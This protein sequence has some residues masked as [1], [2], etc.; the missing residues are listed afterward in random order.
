MSHS[1]ASLALLIA[2]M[3]PVQGAAPVALESNVLQV[4]GQSVR[5]ETFEIPSPVPGPDGE[6]AVIALTSFRLEGQD[7]RPAP[8]V[9]HANGFGLPRLQELGPP[10]ASKG[11]SFWG[12]L[13]ALASAVVLD[14]YHLVS[15]DHRGHGGSGGVSRSMDPFYEIV[16]VRTV[17]DWAEEN[18]SV[19]RDDAGDPLIGTIG[20]SFG[21]GYQLL[22]A[23]FD[24][25]VDAIVPT[26]TWNDLPRS[27]FGFGVLKQG[28]LEFECQ[29]AVR[30]GTRTDRFFEQACGG[31]EQPGAALVEQLGSPEDVRS[32]LETWG[33]SGLGHLE[34]V[35]DQEATGRVLDPRLANVEPRPIDA[36]LMQAS[37]DVL[38][39]LNEALANQRVLER[40]GGDVRLVVLRSGHANPAAG[41]GNGPAT[42]GDLGANEMTLAF[43]ARTLRGEAD[44]TDLPEV[45][46][47]VS[48][49]AS[50]KLVRLP[51]LVAGRKVAV[52]ESDWSEGAWVFHPIE[53]LAEARDLIG[54]PRFT[55]TVAAVE[56]ADQSIG[57]VGLAVRTDGGDPALLSGQLVAL[58][59]GRYVEVELAGVA[60]R[61]DAGTTLGL[62][63]FETHPQ[64]RRPARGTPT[65]GVL[66]GNRF[67]LDGEVRLPRLLEVE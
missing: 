62:L 13:R 37:E 24:P 19:A 60:D 47:A 32:M 12:Q 59:P 2:T 64:F 39:P 1:L 28:W 61:L 29:M 46:V 38:F 27:L 48:R 50:R 52:T 21:G 25:R 53:T 22:L 36:L 11:A 67:V 33:R 56:G 45:C 9:L 7:D 20:G 16:D 8:L 31:S 23:A 58:R 55:G 15:F 4:G 49:S 40:G 35:W 26:M 41:Q 10:Q 6:T 54:V 66:E 30:G 17:L 43:F 51:E 65:A 57:L 3:S 14:G 18:L 5:V 34:T 44:T 42:C 63:A